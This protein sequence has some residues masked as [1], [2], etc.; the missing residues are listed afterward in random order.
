MDS[1]IVIMQHRI[2]LLAVLFASLQIGSAFL[3][4]RISP[5]NQRLPK[6]LDK[7]CQ[8]IY[9]LLSFPRAY[10]SITV[11]STQPVSVRVE[12]EMTSLTGEKETFTTE[13]KLMCYLVCCRN[14]PFKL[15]RVL[16]SR[17]RSEIKKSSRNL[18]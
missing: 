1:I 3:G 8:N 4:S 16:R 10:K 5:T 6:L 14:R 18:Y 9:G 17:F 11:V 12:M 13:G 7:T 2:L 15:I